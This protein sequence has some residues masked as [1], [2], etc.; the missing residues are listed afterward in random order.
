MFGRSS[1][2]VKV[3]FLAAASMLALV[4]SVDQFPELLLLTD[5]TTNDFT[6]RKGDL[7]ACVLIL[8]AANHTSIPLRPKGCHC[9]EQIGRPQMLEDV[10]PS[11]ADF[12]LLSVLRT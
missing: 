8:S 1:V 12:L 2:P 4:V 5:N 6:I 11:S 9:E 7:A 3:L 10:E